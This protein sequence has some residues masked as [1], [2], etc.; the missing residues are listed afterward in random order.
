MAIV[1][2]TL[3]RDYDRFRCQKCFQHHYVLK[4]T[5]NA[6]RDSLCWI[7]RIR[8]QRDK[9]LVKAIL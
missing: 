6:E 8:I 7:C 2:E 4:G 9:T 5:P 3:E 1:T